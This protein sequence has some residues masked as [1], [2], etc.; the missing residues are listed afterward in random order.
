[1]GGRGKVRMDA[2]RLRWGGSGDWRVQD[3][4]DQ[5]EAEST[6]LAD[7]LEVGGHGGPVRESL[8]RGDS[9]LC[10]EGRGEGEGE[11]RQ[12]DTGGGEFGTCL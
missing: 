5:L 2:C 7:V 1:M 10:M 9:P 12:T 8:W 6:R 4:G 3:L 11:W